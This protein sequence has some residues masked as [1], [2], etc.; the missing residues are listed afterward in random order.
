MSLF[1]LTSGQK[2]LLSHF[3]QF[4][5]KALN[6]NPTLNSHRKVNKFAYEH[7]R[8]FFNTLRNLQQFE[9]GYLK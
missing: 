2:P 5:V 4:A 7:D 6:L 3:D 1:L 8:H 9:T